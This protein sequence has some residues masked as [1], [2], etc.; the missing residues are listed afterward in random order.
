MG[1]REALNERID[2]ENVSIYIVFS[3]RNF[4]R[5][6]NSVFSSVGSREA[7]FVGLLIVSFLSIV[8][9]FIVRSFYRSYVLSFVR[10]IVRTFYRSFRSLTITCLFRLYRFIY[11]RL[12]SFVLSSSCIQERTKVALCMDLHAFCL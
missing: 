6:S 4:V 5:Y 1:S 10:F 3:C 12:R 8:N 7:F 2:N 11:V 9:V